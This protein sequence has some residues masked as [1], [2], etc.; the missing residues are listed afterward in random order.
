MAAANL[1]TK[2]PASRLDYPID[3]SD[4]LE[5]GD[6]I[7]VSAWTVP[8]GITVATSS[9]TTTTAT[10]WLT[11]GT[12]G[13]TYELVNHITTAA[14]REEDQTLLIKMVAK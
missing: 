12:L 3:W 9:N 6:T 5:D 7:T 4:W 11:G 14:G 13:Q 1:K 10:V 2:D 8:A